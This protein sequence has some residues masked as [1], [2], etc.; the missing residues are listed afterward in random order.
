MDETHEQQ[1]DPLPDEALE[2]IE[3]EAAAVA[4]DAAEAAAEEAAE[5]AEAAERYERS[6]ALL[7]AADPATYHKSLAALLR[8]G[9]DGLLKPMPYDAAKPYHDPACVV[10]EP[11]P[12]G[13]DTMRLYSR[14]AY[15]DFDKVLAEPFN[16]PKLNHL[17]TSIYHLTVNEGRNIAVVTNHGELHDIAIVLSAL[18]LALCDEDRTFGVLGETVALENMAD[19]ANLLLSRMVATTEVF[20]IP[21]TEVLQEMCRTFY[22]VPQTASRRR[23]RL[24]PELVRANNV[25]MRQN[26][27]DQLA[28]GGQILAMAASGS[29]DISVAGGVARFI[30]SAWRQR[31]GEER[32]DVPSLHLQPLYNGTMNL[33]MTCD[34][35]LPVAISLNPD[36]LACEVGDLTKVRSTDDCH[37]VMHWIAETHERA[38]GIATVY[39]ARE[40]DLLTQVRDALRR[41]DAR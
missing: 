16:D 27:G 33:M 14:F 25:V 38:T 8:T 6:L 17:L 40:D 1:S 29:Q 13:L 19:R 20:N 7:Q 23:S 18:V 26:L 24:D 36:H 21:T 2:A 9:H 12:T 35:V 39:H 4:A 11:R 15:R 41:T 3:L 22:S 5:A 32:D 31:R 10:V 37:N 30:R 34:Y 28:K